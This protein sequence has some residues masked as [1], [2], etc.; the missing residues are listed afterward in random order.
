M[1]ILITGAN[2]FL[3]SRLVESFDDDSGVSILGT[4]HRRKGSLRRKAS[5]KLSYLWAE[6]ADREKTYE[7]FKQNCIEAVI[8]AAAS[9]SKRNDADYLVEA[10]DNNVRSQAN[11]ISAAVEC[12][13]KRYVYCSSIS[14]YGRIPEKSG[15]LS[16]NDPKA[17]A[18]IYGWSKIH[19]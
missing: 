16:E 15:F 19:G 7:I 18:D 8:H 2:G 10:L 11:L 1:N 6:L 4:L 5:R 12:G 13:C 14:V 3:G 9:I 17:F